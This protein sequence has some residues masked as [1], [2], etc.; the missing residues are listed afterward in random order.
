MRRLL[1]AVVIGAM[2]TSTA[3]PASGFT[4]DDFRPMLTVNADAGAYDA[5]RL[6]EIATVMSKSMNERAAFEFVEKG[7]SNHL[8]EAEISDLAVASLQ[9]VIAYRWPAVRASRVIFESFHGTI[10]DV[11]DLD[12]EINFMTADEYAQVRTL[13][14][15]DVPAARKL[16]FTKLQAKLNAATGR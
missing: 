4:A 10:D 15:T 12:R 14:E 7:V 8:T 16:A 6:A 5:G 2:M 1:S 11:R 9:M 13:A 3:L